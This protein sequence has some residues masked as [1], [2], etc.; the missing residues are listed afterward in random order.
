MSYFE[1]GDAIATMMRRARIVKVD[2]SGSQQIVTYRALAGEEGKAYRQQGHGASSN[3][4]I[5]SEGWILALGGRSDRP[6]FLDG[7]HEKHRPRN[8]PAGG[9]VIYDHKGNVSKYLGDGGIWH[10]AG[11]RPHK[12]TG[13][14]LEHKASG[15][16]SFGGNVTYIG[17]NGTDGTYAA[18]MTASG[19]SSSVFCKL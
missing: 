10:D 13:G 19:P 17:G 6:L 7:E 18:V 15:K 11:S 4:P 1:H 16:A 3:P 5:G 14:T 8:T 12:M 2:D 9:K